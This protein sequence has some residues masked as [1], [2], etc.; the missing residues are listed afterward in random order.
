MFNKYKELFE[1]YLRVC[2]NKYNPEKPYGNLEDC[3]TTAERCLWQLSGML[4]LIESMGEITFEEKDKE[5]H[6]I[7]EVFST[8][9]LY[10]AFMEKGE[11]MVWSKSS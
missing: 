11:V 2:K 5:F 8:H 3:C 7:L 10:N 4:D 6:R 1:I 9:N